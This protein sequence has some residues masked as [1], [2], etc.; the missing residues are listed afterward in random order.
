MKENNM[1]KQPKKF[2]IGKYYQRI[3]SNKIIHVLCKTITFT[4]GECLITED[5]EGN[6]QA[7]GMTE[8]NTVGYYEVSGWHQKLYAINNIPQ[9][10]IHKIKKYENQS[11]L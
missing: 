5:D 2:E 1:K 4:Y 8:D 7:T 11:N 3:D 10:E 9:P 6:F